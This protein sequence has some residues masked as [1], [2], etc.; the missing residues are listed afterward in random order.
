[1]MRSASLHAA[2]QP[3]LEVVPKTSAPQGTQSG[4]AA[5]NRLRVQER[6]KIRPLEDETGSTRC[7]RGVLLVV[8]ATPKSVRRRHIFFCRSNPWKAT[9]RILCYLITVDLPP[10]GPAAH[11]ALQQGNLP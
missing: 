8:S 11:H 2:P 9:S 3:D 1:M 5:K 6:R 7:E 10:E 4:A